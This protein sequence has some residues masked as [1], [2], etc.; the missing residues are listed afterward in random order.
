M[1]SQVHRYQEIRE[2][3]EPQAHKGRQGWF[4]ELEV[5]GGRAECRLQCAVGRDTQ[6]QGGQV[7]C[8]GKQN[9]TAVTVAVIPGADAGR[10]SF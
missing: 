7:S 9:H 8:L 4:P 5:F 2:R 1:V 6:S 3:Q 10:C